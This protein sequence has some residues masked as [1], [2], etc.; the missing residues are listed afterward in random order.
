MRPPRT[1]SAAAMSG[2]HEGD[3]IVAVDGQAIQSVPQ[4]QAAIREH[5][6]GEEIKV[7]IRRCPGDP[8]EITLIRTLPP[9]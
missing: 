5:E 9:R 2:L 3:V 1:N 6:P 8:L 7:R 4:L